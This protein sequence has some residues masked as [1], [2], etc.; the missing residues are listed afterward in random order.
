MKIFT[1]VYLFIYFYTVAFWEHSLSRT[2]LWR[3]TGRE[4]VDGP[5]S[6]N[7]WGLLSGFPAER[8]T[9]SNPRL[10]RTASEDSTRFIRGCLLRI[11]ST[12]P[13]RIPRS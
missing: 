13:E 9:D 1:R 12:G 5:I 4:K 6:L 7:N 3:G 8:E 11:L 10:D 2:S